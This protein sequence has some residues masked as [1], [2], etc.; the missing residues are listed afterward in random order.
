MFFQVVQHPLNREGFLAN[1][2]DWNHEFLQ[3]MATPL[4]INLNPQVE[5]IV[6]IARQFYQ[7][8]G[9]SPNMKA[10][11]KYLQQQGLEL[12]SSQVYL[13]FNGHGA[14]EI[15]RLAGLPRPFSCIR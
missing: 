7:E 3:A 12:D 15:C 9:K 6:S 1:P 4:E 10:L 13:L 8:F 2:Q 11:M 5:E 14:K